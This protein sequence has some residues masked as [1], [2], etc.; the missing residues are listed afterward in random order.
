MTGQQ[1]SIRALTSGGDL[2]AFD[3]RESDQLP[4]GD[5]R[6]TY[7]SR[8]EGP[9]GATHIAEW[10]CCGPLMVG[11]A[12][13][14]RPLTN[15]FVQTTY[16]RALRHNI[17]AVIAVSKAS[18]LFPVESSSRFDVPGRATAPREA[19][20]WEVELLALLI[21]AFIEQLREQGARR[22]TEE[23]TWHVPTEWNTHG[24][25][26]KVD[27]EV[28]EFY[29]A[30]ASATPQIMEKRQ[31]PLIVAQLQKA[32]SLALRAIRS[33]QPAP[34]PELQISPVRA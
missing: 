4:R 26:Q 7:V 1:F 24:P 31:I 30:Y 3:F 8:G 25:L 2:W 33:I 12:A 21:P 5:T 19:I 9:G 6:A 16:A 17:D 20:L 23:M 14:G 29:D 11:R 18:I 34:W 27:P 22:G 28:T 32:E 15:A 13:E 10:S